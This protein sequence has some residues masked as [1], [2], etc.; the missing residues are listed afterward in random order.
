[1]P[2]RSLDSLSSAFY[3]K[4]CALI[5]HVTARGVACMVA[6][7]GRT[8]AEHQQNLLAG[9]SGTMLSLHLPRYMRWRPEAEWGL[10]LLDADR[11]KSDAIDL[12]PYEQYQLHG[13]DKANYDGLDPAYGVICEVAERLGLRSGGRWRKPFDPGHA[14]LVLPWK[15]TLLAEERARPWPAFRTV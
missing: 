9:T 13:P 8:V 11:E 4:A 7:T 14:E 3:P 1:M 6:Q 12:V 15:V 5:A 10:A 2:D